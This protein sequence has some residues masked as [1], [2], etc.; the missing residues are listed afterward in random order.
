MPIP[1]ETVAAQ[2]RRG[3]ALRASLPPSRRGGTSIGLARANQLANREEVS[4]DTIRRM[5][6]YFDRHEIDK[7]G[8]GWGRDSKGYQAWLLWGGDPGRAWAREVW[9]EYVR[10]GAE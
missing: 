7:E 9:A 2:A 3:L 5:I 8:E 4:I 1:P 10:E 6:S